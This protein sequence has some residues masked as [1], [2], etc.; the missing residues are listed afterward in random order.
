MWTMHMTKKVKPERYIYIYL[1]YLVYVIKWWLI[2]IYL[3]R[4]QD[5]SRGRRCWG[6]WRSSCWSIAV[7][8]NA[9]PEENRRI[10][11]ARFCRGRTLLCIRRSRSHSAICW[12]RSPTWCKRTPPSRSA[13]PASPARTASHSMTPHTRT[14][15]PSN[16]HTRCFL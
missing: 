14:T 8:Q 11:Q 2:Y 6:R 16:S 12:P 13:A 4:R 9:V 7:L 10:F 3:L 5:W 1:N 15:L